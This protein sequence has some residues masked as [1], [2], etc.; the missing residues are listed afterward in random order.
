MVDIRSRADGALAADSGSA[1]AVASV[2]VG[3]SFAAA[4]RV[5]F[6]KVIETGADGTGTIAGVITGAGG[7]DTTVDTMADTERPSMAASPTART[8]AVQAVT[9]TTGATG[10]LTPAVTTDGITKS[11]ISD[12]RSHGPEN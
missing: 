8:T 12:E 6:V 11:R 9:T 4:A 2:V 1:A 3:D 10:I 5:V 7:A